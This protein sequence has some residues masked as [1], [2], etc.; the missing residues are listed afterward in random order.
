MSAAIDQAECYSKCFAVS[1][2]ISVPGGPWGE[3]RVP[4]VFS[5]NGRAYLKQIETESGI[6]FRDVRRPANL[7]RL[8]V[9]W[10]TPQGLSDRL[11]IDRD[12]AQAALKVSRLNSGFL[13]DLTS[14]RH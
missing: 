14:A 9:D 4:F 1:V 6:W 5:A 11:Q 8:L 12:S 7:R 10:V 3:F 2:E 13:S